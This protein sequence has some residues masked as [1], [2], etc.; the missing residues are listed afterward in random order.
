[1]TA[2]S[3]IFPGGGDVSADTIWDTKG[4]L[5]GGTGADTAA[6]LAIGTNGD[7][8]IADSSEA[9]GMKWASPDV[10]GAEYGLLTLSVNQTTG[11]AVGDEV[12]F[13]TQSGGNLTFNSTTH[14]VTLKAGRTYRL[15]ADVFFESSS[16]NFLTIQWYDVTNSIFI[17]QSS[18]FISVNFSTANSS[19]TKPIA[20]ITPSSDML[21]ELRIETVYAALI[22]INSSYTHAYIETIGGIGGDVAADTIWDAK[23][24]LAGG[25]G[26]NTA[27][28][29]AIGTNDHVLTA[30]SSEATGMKWAEASGGGAGLAWELISANDTAVSGEGFLINASSGNVTLTLPAS[31]SEGD[32]VGVCDV[33]DKATTNTITVGRNGSNIEGSA[34]DLVIDI[35]GSGMVLVYADATRGWKIVSEIRGGVG[36]STLTSNTSSETVADEAGIVLA[37]GVS[38][39]GFAQAGDNEQ[40]IQFS[41]TAAGVVTVIANSALAINTDTDGNLCVYDAGSGIAIKNRLGASKTIRYAVNYSA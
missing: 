14:Q 35:D 13:N 30:D 17:G 41:F 18:Q 23:G 11:L 8:L 20:I 1:M 37:T 7:V 16:A 31:P 22:N 40:W 19:N 6:K 34:S 2:L 39:W 9:T 12:Q 21:V 28:K 15:E 33:Y 29:L 3:T 25:T 4:D 27:A 32:T 38:G 5:V 10:A 36:S 26:A 24:D